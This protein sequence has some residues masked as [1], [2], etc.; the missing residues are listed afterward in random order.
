[1]KPHRSP[2]P[3]CVDLDGTLVATDTLLESLLVL[4]KRRPLY[5]LLLPWWLIRGRASFKQ[6]VA[7][8]APL[9]VTGLPYRHDFLYFL[10]E[11]KEAGHRLIL[12]TAAD[13]QHALPCSAHLGLFDEVLAS[14]GKVNLTG[15]AKLRAIKSALGGESFIYAGNS[16]ADLAI[17][18]NAAQAVIVDVPPRV[19]SRL[20]REG[21]GIQRVFPRTARPFR[22]LL[23]A[24]RP[25]HWAKNLLLF[26]PAF[27]AHRLFELSTVVETL[28]A[29]VAFS[30]CASGGYVLNDMLD[31]QADRQH[32]KK[33]H[34]PL[35]SGE[36]PLG[37]AYWTVP[38]LLLASAG[39]ASLLN[40][41][42]HHLLF[43]YLVL[44]VAYSGYLKSLVLADVIALTTMYTMRIMAGGAATQISVSHWLLAFSAFMFL[45]LSLLKRFSE[46]RTN[47][48]R[49]E[50]VVHGRGYIGVDLEQ[51]A[52]FGCA[53]GYAAVLVLALYI[54][55][56]DVRALYRAPG[57]L[58]LLCPLMLFWISR[59][60]LLARRGQIEEDPL[61]FAFKDK[62][63]YF[64]G[65][66]AA[67]IVAWAA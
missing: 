29:F 45:S 14:D 38:L 36:L 30:L 27:T 40:P 31:L 11:Q 62:T 52:I 46:V 39:A 2:R 5:L 34:R 51:L 57:R 56:A 25:L 44:N 6:K 61:L 1:M 10:K 28:I 53:S 3:L 63:N 8:V 41:P 48:L 50:N 58:W 7:E 21:V 66:L 32:L 18:R 59:A 55:S 4:V 16:S 64:W 26:V 54:A 15:Q 43:F 19:M 13:R 22:A 35:A 33:R 20:R 67:L 17:W 42:F 65:L 12:A 47:V 9:D 37:V 23:K 60:W 24:I 49:R